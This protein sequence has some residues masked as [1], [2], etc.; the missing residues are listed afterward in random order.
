MAAIVG[1]SHG[2]GDS[3]DLRVHSWVSFVSWV[4]NCNRNIVYHYATAMVLITKKSAKEFTVLLTGPSIDPATRKLLLRGI[5]RAKTTIVLMGAALAL[6]L[7]QIKD[8]PVLAVLVGLTLNL[9][10][11]AQ[12]VQTVIRLRKILN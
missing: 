3:V 5:R 6:A 2:R 8:F 1:W 12:S 7:I 11:T 10:I 4:W 9:L